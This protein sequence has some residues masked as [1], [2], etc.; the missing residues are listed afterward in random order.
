M[1]NERL[2]STVTDYMIIALSPALIMCLVGSLV[3]FLAEITYVGE[4]GARLR[5]ILF[6]FVFGSVLVSRISMDADTYLAGR[7]G[8]YGFILGGLT[9]FSMGQFVT[10]DQAGPFAGLDSITNLFLVATTWWSAHRLTWDC[11]FIDDTI[12][13]SGEG[14][15]QTAGLD[16]TPSQPEAEAADEADEDDD[17]VAAQPRKKKGRKRKVE[18]P[19]GIVGWWSRYRRYREERE[20]RPHNPGLWVVYFSLAALP[21]FGLGQAWIP[22]TDTA[23][24]QQAFWLMVIYVASGLGLLL[25]TA[26]LGLRRYLRQRKLEMPLTISGLW[27]MTGGGLIVAL[28]LAGA[29]LPRPYAE[30]TLF[31]ATKAKSQERSASDYSVKDG[32]TGKDQGRPSS[33][34]TSDEKG[35]PGS[36][37]RPGKDGKGE[38]QKKAADGKQKSDASDKAKGDE[39]QKDAKSN[40]SSKQQSDRKG[41]QA[42]DSAGEK[43]NESNSSRSGNNRPSTP[44]SMNW[45][46]RIPPA[47]TNVVRGVL[48]VMLAL[49]GIWFLIKFLANFTHWAKWLVDLLRNL[50]QNLFGGLSGGTETEAAADE[51]EPALPAPRPFGSYRNPFLAGQPRP[52]EEIV[53]YCFEALEAF[54]FE[55]DLARGPDETPLEFADRFGRAVPALEADVHR[56]AALYARAAYS[57]SRLSAETIEPLRQFWDKMDVAYRQ[58][59]VSS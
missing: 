38:G 17:E 21:L 14:L 41:D 1:S 52:P 8:M 51:A 48:Y 3:F 5:W 26:F 25:T 49:A 42:K 28:L 33:E 4:Y 37:T 22:V 11:T 54:A 10:Y 30:Y 46:P 32:D 2:H 35:T 53:R 55:C 23:R 39:R 31:D 6:C 57:R 27:L 24:R 59:P 29:L 16:E 43:K 20:R 45:M 50:W 9:W 56:L 47:L 19:T 44:R 34:K 36:K 15:L 40:D 12:D 13:A 18:E 7:A 58:I